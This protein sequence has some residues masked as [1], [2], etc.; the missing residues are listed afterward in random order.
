[1]FYTAKGLYVSAVMQQPS[2]SLVRRLSNRDQLLNRDSFSVTLDTSGEGLYGY[3]FELSL[4]GSKA[5]GK[6]APE[7]LL[8]PANGM[9]HGQAKQLSLITAGAPSCLSLGQSSACPI[10]RLNGDLT[11]GYNAKWPNAQ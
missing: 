4:G 7:P 3:W 6:L 1:M 5:D 11:F 8:S 10:S 2:E 9:A